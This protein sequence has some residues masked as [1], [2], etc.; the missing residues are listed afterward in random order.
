MVNQKKLEEYMYLSLIGKFNEKKIVNGRTILSFIPRESGNDFIPMYI[1]ST[2][3]VKDTTSLN[4]IKAFESKI[5]AD[6]KLL[7]KIKEIKPTKENNDSVCYVKRIK[8]YIKNNNENKN[9]IIESYKNNLDKLNKESI[10][11]LEEKGIASEFMFECF[12]KENKN[13]LQF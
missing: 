12:N 2:E 6:T 13:I 5:F 7:E 8:E 1:T 10:V 4:K 11:T 3:M 9:Y